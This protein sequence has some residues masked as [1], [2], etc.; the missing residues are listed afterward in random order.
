VGRILARAQ[1]AVDTAF[2]WGFQKVRQAGGDEGQAR[3][4]RRRNRFLG[5]AEGLGRRLLRVVGDAGDEFY[6]EY[7]RLKARRDGSRRS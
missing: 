6:R 2:G 5:T 7:E 1:H 3:S 4:R